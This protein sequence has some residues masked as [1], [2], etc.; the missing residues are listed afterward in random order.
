MYSILGL[1]LF[2]HNAKFNSLTGNVDVD[3]GVSPMLNFDDF[4]NSVATVFAMLT[5]D[6]SSSVYYNYYRAVDPVASTLFWVSFT[7]F[8]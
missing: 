3:N 1:E 8:A 5:N 2:Q 7:V 6:P 4:R